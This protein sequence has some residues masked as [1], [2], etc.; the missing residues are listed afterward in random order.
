[1]IEHLPDPLVPAEVDLRDFEY[2]PLYVRRLRD[3]RFVSIRTPEEVLAGIMLWSASWH[4]VPAGSLPDDEIELST[5][6]GY[7]GHRGVSLFRK[8]K[9]G[10]L[11]NFVRCSDGRLYHPVVAEAARASWAGKVKEAWRK[12]ADKW[13]KAHP[14]TVFPDVDT[15]NKARLSDGNDLSFRWNGP[16]IPLEQRASSNGKH[17]GADGIPLDSPPKGSV[18]EGKS[19]GS[20]KDNGRDSG[21]PTRYGEVAAWLHGQGVKVTSFNPDLVAWVDELHASDDQLRETLQRCRVEKPA[22]EQIPA[23]YFDTCL[24][25]LI[26]QAGRPPR[27]VRPARREDPRAAAARSIGLGDPPANDDDGV[28]DGTAQRV[29]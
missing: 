24:R 2:M 18:R 13:R 22:P 14:K 9:D 10:A 28:I 27:I 21:A 26:A 20:I 11:H 15:W 4:Q 16:I 19:K 17:G 1:M 25:N 7:G 12:D 6:A 5:L 8:V 3:S 23:R 29:G